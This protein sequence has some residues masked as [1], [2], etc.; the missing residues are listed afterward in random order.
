VPPDN[1]VLRI[2]GT[3]L[4]DSAR[5]AIEG[6]NTLRV[7]HK[8]DGEANYTT[9]RVS[10]SSVRVVS[11]SGRAGDDTLD[12]LYDDTDLA[13]NPLPIIVADGGAGADF[14]EGGARNDTLRGGVGAYKDT[15]YGRDGRDA[16]YG[17]DGNDF[18]D[19][20]SGNDK[21]FG[22]GG[23]YDKLYGQTGNDFLDDGSGLTTEQIMPGYGGEPDFIARRPADGGAT[24]GDVLQRNGVPDCQLVASLGAVANSSSNRLKERIYYVAPEQY[25]VKLFSP[26]A[27]A[28]RMYPVHFDGTLTSTDPVI[29]TYHDEFWTVLYKRSLEQLLR[30]EGSPGVITPV[31]LEALTGRNA[32]DVRQPFAS[33]AT[34]KGLLAD[35]R[36]VV[37][38]SFSG[39]ISPYLVANHA[40]TV[41]RV[42]AQDRIVLRNPWGVDGARAS[43]SASDGLVYLTW[44]EF[45]A[46]GLRYWYA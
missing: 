8:S 16:I 30:E 15:I 41:L 46:S 32:S 20:G 35:N 27:N 2:L 25:E 1:G 36:P 12:N 43:G 38:G 7:Q 11:F 9:Y 19:G 45:K 10:A 14:L 31:V 44:A 28:W 18:L 5:L 21:M 22:E 40:Y 33:F 42:D 13:D 34:L 24:Y 3:D 17:G 23:S 37:S 26:S 6:G 4:D 39:G 29:A